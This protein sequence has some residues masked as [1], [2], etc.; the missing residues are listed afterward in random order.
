MRDK[1]LLTLIL[2]MF[3]ISFTSAISI[4]TFQHSK[5]VELY[6]TCNNCTYCN[7]T[8][9]KYPNST[10]ILTN[11]ETIKDGSYFYFVLKG[12]NT[13]DIL[14]TYTYVYDCGNAVEKLTGDIHFEVTNRGEIFSIADSILY[15]LL[16]LGSVLILIFSL[17]FAI[18]LPAVNTR[19]EEFKI[20]SVNKLKYLKMTF[21]LLTYGLFVW[22]LNLLLGISDFLSFSIYHGFFKFIF[23]I[24]INIS[25]PLLIV[26]GIIFLLMIKNDAKVGKMLRRGFR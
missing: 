1:I 6:Q 25:Y 11:V 19:S 3:L 24:L 17:Y 12:G 4:G 5:D 10:N 16:F 20:M 9:I 13:T 8:T 22:V 15:F 26:W 7:F 14:G 2:G 21:I 23:E 18:F